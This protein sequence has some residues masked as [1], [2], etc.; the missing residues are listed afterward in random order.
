MGRKEILCLTLETP[1]YKVYLND[2]PAFTLTHF[3]PGQIL[4]VN[5]LCLMGNFT[6]F[7]NLEMII[8]IYR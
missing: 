7:L 5:V 4:Y 2:G 1:A 6:K 3:M 8:S